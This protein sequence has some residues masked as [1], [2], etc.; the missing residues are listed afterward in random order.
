MEIRRLI[1]AFTVFKLVNLRSC[2]QYLYC[3]WF[4]DGGTSK[5]VFN[6]FLTCFKLVFNLFLT[7][8]KATKLSKMIYVNSYKTTLNTKNP[9]Y[10][11]S[12]D[13]NQQLTSFPCEAIDQQ[14]VFLPV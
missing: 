1:K 11:A 7:C 14:V 8:Y 2:V 5:L 3:A 6:L 9:P 4:L 10:Y 13:L 12:F